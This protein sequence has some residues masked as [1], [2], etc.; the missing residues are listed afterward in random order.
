[1]GL[2]LRRE[3]AYVSNRQV[4]GDPPKSRPKYRTS[5]M[6]P[7]A[8]WDSATRPTRASI[9]WATTKPFVRRFVRRFDFISTAAQ[10]ALETSL[11]VGIRTVMSWWSSDAVQQAGAVVAVGPLVEA[12]GVMDV[13]SAWAPGGQA[14]LDFVTGLTQEHHPISIGL[15]WAGAPVVERH[16]MTPVLADLALRS[17]AGA[18]FSWAQQEREESLLMRPMP[19]PQGRLQASM[20]RA[21][22]HRINWL[23]S[24]RGVAAMA[25]EVVPEPLQSAIAWWCD[26]RFR[27]STAL[28]SHYG[29][30]G[31]P[32]HL[33][34]IGRIWGWVVAGAAA[35][36]SV[37][38]DWEVIALLSRVRWQVVISRLD[39]AATP[40][41]DW[42][43]TTPWVWPLAL[44]RPVPLAL[45]AE[46]R[47]SSE[48]TI[49][50]G[51]QALLE[52]L[53]AYLVCHG[54]LLT[55][56]GRAG[57]GWYRPELNIDALIL[58]MGWL[59]P[60]ACTTWCLFVLVASTGIWR[61][62]RW[63]ERPGVVWAGREPAPRWV[64]IFLRLRRYPPD[65]LWQVRG[66]P[67]EH[68]Q[69]LAPGFVPWIP[70]P[71]PGT[72]WMSVII[73]AWSKRAVSQL[74]LASAAA[75]LLGLTGLP[76]AYC[77]ALFATIQW[78]DQAVN[79]TE[80]FTSPAL[81]L[82]APLPRSGFGTGNG[83]GVSWRGAARHHPRL[84]KHGYAFDSVPIIGSGFGPRVGLA[85]DP[86]PAMDDQLPTIASPGV[87]AAVVEGRVSEARHCFEGIGLGPDVS[88]YNGGVAWR[89]AAAWGVK[90]QLYR[91][92][93]I[94][95]W[96]GRVVLPENP[97]QA[98]IAAGEA[99]ASWGRGQ[100]HLTH[101]ELVGALLQWGRVRQMD[102]VWL[103]ANGHATL[104]LVP[105]WEPGAV[106]RPLIM[107]VPP[108]L[109]GAP[110]N[111]VAWVVNL[112]AAA[113]ANDDKWARL[114]L[115]LIAAVVRWTLVQSGTA[116][117][118]SAAF[119]ERFDQLDGRLKAAH[120]PTPS[121]NRI[122]RDPFRVEAA[123][124]RAS[125]EARL[126]LEEVWIAHQEA[127]DSLR[128][129]GSI[130]GPGREPYRGSVGPV[131]PLRTARGNQ[132][133]EALGE[134]I[135]A[136][137]LAL[138]ARSGA[139]P[140][141]TYTPERFAEA[142]AKWGLQPAESPNL[143]ELVTLVADRILARYPWLFLD[144]AP[145]SRRGLARNLILKYGAG[146]LLEGRTA[147][148][149]GPNGKAHHFIVRTRRDLL[150]LG[151][152]DVMIDA[153][154]MRG[155]IGPAQ[156]VHGGFVKGTVIDEER[157]IADATK[158]RPVTP[159]ALPALLSGAMVGKPL[160]KR[161]TRYWVDTPF[162]LGMPMTNGGFLAR[163]REVAT[164]EW[165][166]AVDVRAFDSI[167]GPAVIREIVRL[168]QLGYVRHPDFEALAHILSDNY[169]ELQ[170]GLI[171]DL[172]SGQLL[173]KRGGLSTGQANVSMDNNLAMQLIMRSLLWRVGG[174]EL[175][176][177]DTTLLNFSDDG[178]LHWDGEASLREALLAAAAEDG[179][180]L[181]LGPALP[182]LIG[183]EFCAKEFVDPAAFSEELARHGLPEPPILVRHDRARFMLRRTLNPGPATVE[184]HWQ[185]ARG[186]LLLTAHH[187]DLYAAVRDD[188]RLI[189][190]EAVGR[191]RWVKTAHIPT[192]REVLELHHRTVDP[193]TTS[194]AQRVWAQF[195]LI[196]GRLRAY[197]GHG[198]RLAKMLGL[199]AFVG[200]RLSAA[201]P[202]EPMDA[203]D[204]I[205][206]HAAWH[207][208]R[209]GQAPSRALVTTM[210]ATSPFANFVA[211][212]TIERVLATPLDDD[213]VWSRTLYAVLLVL[214]QANFV[215]ALATVPFIG[216]PA[217]IFVLLFILIVQAYGL[218]SL[219]TWL[220]RGAT[221][222]AVA[223]CVPRDPW[224]WAKG[225]ALRVAAALPTI[226]GISAIAPMLEVVADAID[227]GAKAWLRAQAVAVGGA[228][229]AGVEPAARNDW[230]PVLL[231]VRQSMARHRVPVLSSATGTGKTTQALRA[232]AA[233]RHTTL[234]ITSTQALRAPVIEI[235][236]HLVRRGSPLMLGRLNVCTAAHGV[237][238]EWYR[239][240]GE[241]DLVVW[242]EAHQ[243]CWEAVEF[244]MLA[245]CRQL[246]LTATPT[247]GLLTRI[248]GA[249]VIS[250]G[251]PRRWPL[252][253]HQS[254]LALEQVVAQEAPRAV[255]EARLLVI[256]PSVARV[257]TLVRY[258]A[259]N[260][261]VAAPYTAGGQVPGTPIIVASSVADAG[262][263]IPRIATVIDSGYVIESAPNGT[264]RRRRVTH[265]EHLQRAGRAG[266]DRPGRGILVGVCN[267]V[268]SMPAVPPLRALAQPAL[269]TQIA[270]LQG[271]PPVIPAGH[272]LAG[273]RV[274]V[275]STA[276]E[277]DPSLDEAI[278]MLRTST[279]P[280]KLQAAVVD[281][282]AGIG[283]EAV[284]L[285]L[286][287]AG[288]AH[289]VWPLVRDSRLVLE[290]DGAMQTVEYLGIVDHRFTKV[291]GY[292]HEP[293]LLAEDEVVL[294]EGPALLDAVALAAASA[295]WFSLR[296]DRLPVPPREVITFAVVDQRVPGQ[297]TDLIG[298]P[299]PPKS[300]GVVLLRRPGADIVAL[301]PTDALRVVTAGIGS[302]N[303]GIAT[304]NT[305]D[306]YA[307]VLRWRHCT[308]GT[309][310]RGRWRRLDQT[311]EDC[312]QGV[313]R[314]L[315]DAWARTYPTKEFPL[316]RLQT[317][318]VGAMAS[319]VPR[320]C[321]L[322]LRRNAVSV[323]APT[324]RVRRH[325]VGGP[326]AL[327]TEEL[328]FVWSQGHVALCTTFG[329]PFD[330][331]GE[332]SP[333]HASQAE[334][335]RIAIRNTTELHGVSG[336]LD[337]DATVVY[338]PAHTT[339][340]ET[341][342]TPFPPP[343]HWAMI[344]EVG[345]ASTRL[346]R[347]IL[348]TKNYRRYLGDAVIEQEGA[349]EHVLIEWPD[350][351]AIF[352]PMN[353][354]EPC[355]NSREPG[356]LAL[357]DD[358]LRTDARYINAMPDA[359]K[360]G[361]HAR[362]PTGY[363]SHWFRDVVVI[364]ALGATHRKRAA[365]FRCL[366]DVL[367]CL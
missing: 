252:D 330:L 44:W 248:P 105:L 88:H 288:S 48:P 354:W 144:H 338:P 133:G 359:R 97:T 215:W 142:V 184:S 84:Y 130:I 24:T 268:E 286:R 242:D 189:R 164:R 58:V 174:P 138:G 90:Q 212:A 119:V 315:G 219:L 213:V 160:H 246:C 168:R 217:A 361:L 77:V 346:R 13:V 67:L 307:S 159:A 28:A 291:P 31:W 265:H 124:Y 313:I 356:L 72:Q 363:R 139:D 29:G 253:L 140:R 251:F 303:S 234:V 275:V 353:R 75:T 269:Y 325:R 334:A 23:R 121:L 267:G 344:E 10:A 287:T 83:F 4:L 192:Y 93:N 122:F 312:V 302:L 40:M 225:N 104:L 143:T 146:P 123:S 6:I 340:C 336:G 27:G 255:D 320:I 165:H 18:G 237:A 111:F 186:H 112:Q 113:L 59:L 12:T 134:A 333:D 355:Y 171:V 70:G 170:H 46:V 74:I 257:T 141:A 273:G 161:A 272:P 26:S 278:I 85:E 129:R 39:L 319:E 62:S 209:R 183:L 220:G 11:I 284:T 55:M 300:H 82:L 76:W 155:R 87:L 211:P 290:L 262:V 348:Q 358:A 364:D 98:E 30:G 145:L 36:P 175:A 249:E 125:E 283:S 65:P 201:M 100:E 214:A 7:T 266:R 73:W 80:L 35:I 206:A 166:M 231:R 151:W 107:E 117:Q 157:L 323:H 308:C 69:A 96:S 81:W 15:R 41:Y 101:P 341:T 182:S 322:V 147:V 173:P 16:R 60:N 45:I 247:A 91:Y 254:F 293:L 137:W 152:L 200:Q 279:P 296:L 210:I 314:H 295:G 176:F 357:V 193:A 301:R 311:H 261:Y 232:L 304:G 86:P 33:M 195:R 351:P 199:G 197:L 337:P 22:E 222:P 172:Y 243:C 324:G 43:R 194:E 185:R 21:I 120:I 156:G 250:T 191:D 19:P 109:V 136:R 294:P 42:L 53:R 95:L 205:V 57:L 17:L 20:L 306:G 347:W 127:V 167:V 221:S 297:A 8:V 235:G 32:A 277:W 230:G 52:W 34:E 181:K 187:P 264:V 153:V 202:D 38:A 49:R 218:T 310:L 285:I 259:E 177:R 180:E 110:A 54:N 274:A 2:E 158:M 51:A 128:P 327:L 132:R 149:F 316:T 258:L 148:R 79:A 150:K 63:V 196:E 260:G 349:G 102:Q 305:L 14:A 92:H 68:L 78:S 216:V 108:M 343:L 162:A 135:R 309:C 244:L 345:I 204:I 198:A 229:R 163:Y 66:D 223:G 332:R 116:T 365:I 321:C 335:M 226:E 131:R 245:R 256:E 50:L 208:R 103:L 263:N 271:V 99:V 366:P 25:P 106:P 239:Q 64:N 360:A 9:R 169:T 241:A 238:A 56:C 3:E 228:T 352:T 179:I 190:E 5:I 224:R 280:D 350:G 154:V 37:G 318:L 292:D 227:A 115:D 298:D 126:G 89:V 1:M 281:A 339:W 317:A 188:I 270:Q 236:A 47:R 114:A 240:L 207:V 362:L 118:A 276:M 329:G 367:E 61:H 289:N 178:T 331:H 299:R 328:A 71:Q 326:G 233:G 282:F 94:P 203:G 342:G